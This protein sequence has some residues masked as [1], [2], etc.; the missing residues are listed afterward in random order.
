MFLFSAYNRPMT[1]RPALLALFSTI[2]LGACNELPNEPPSPPTE[3]L[4]KVL[5]KPT[6]NPKK[7]KGRIV[8]QPLVAGLERAPDPV[9]KTS[10]TG[11]LL[12]SY[13]TGLL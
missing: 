3:P 9:G 11:S 12:D 5:A 2:A 1:P 4:S 10:P 6:A 7:P 13:L 8:V